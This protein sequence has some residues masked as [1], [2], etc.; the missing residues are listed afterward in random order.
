MRVGL[1]SRLIAGA[2]VLVALP[3]AGA[4]AQ[5]LQSP[6]AGRYSV[7]NLGTPRG[8]PERLG[9]LT[10][11]AGTTNRLLIGGNANNADGAFYEIGL[12][13][14][15]SGHIVGFSGAATR[16]ASAPNID[17]GAT[18]GPG[19]VLFFTRFPNNDLGQIR[20]GSS[21]PNKLIGLDPFRVASSVGAATFVPPGQPGAGRLKLASYPG[22]QWYDAGV[23]A[24]GSGTYNLTGVANRPASEL[25]NGPEGV[26]YVAPGSPQFS[27]SSILVS[28]YSAGLVGTYRVNGSGDPIVS[29]RRTFISGLQGAEGAFFDPSSGD[30]M[31]STYGGGNRVVVVRGFAPPPPVLGRSVNLRPV[32]GRVLVRLPAGSSSAGARAA[33][34]RGSRFVPLREARQIPVGSLLDTRRGTVRLASARNSSGGTQSGDFSGGV[35][36]VV[37][38]RRRNPRGLTE[39]RLRSGSFRNCT[40]RGSAATVGEALAQT[41]RRTRRRVRRLRGNARGRFR[42]RGRYSAA[43]VRGT[44]WTVD[45]RCDGT[46]TSV[47]RGRVD[48]RDFKRRRTIRLR[49]GR[50]Y[51]ARAPG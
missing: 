8:V 21:A 41:A 40:A 9:G 10:I 16:Y 1:K 13:R 43:T 48:V 2:V 47:R 34:S 50:R 44:V 30:F 24:D 39:L 35:F 27:G 33:G 31:F 4:S 18:Y 22:G 28:E 23:V 32:R 6:F 15:A 42:T 49:A 19:D 29:S 26:V 14:D 20:P 45:D 51:L 25:T 17:G 12:R 46:L 7:V 38:A 3:P 11:K 5:T 36:Q 37:Q